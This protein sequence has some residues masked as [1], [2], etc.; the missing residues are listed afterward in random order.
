MASVMVLVM[1]SVMVLV[2]GDGDG[3]DV[4]PPEIITKL[5]QITL[6]RHHLICHSDVTN[7]FYSLPLDQNLQNPKKLNLHLPHAFFFHGSCNGLVLCSTSSA[8]FLN[9]H[10]LVVFNP[11]TKELVQLPECGFDKIINM[12]ECD[13]MY[14]FGYDARTDDYKVVTFCYIHN[15][16]DVYI[17]SLRSKRWTRPVVVNCPCDHSHPHSNG[18]T[19]PVVFVNGIIHW[20]AYKGPYCA[21]VIVGFSLSDETFTEV[22]SPKGV[23]IV[24]TSDCALVVVGEKL[25]VFLNDEV[26]LMSEY[27]VRESWFKISICGFDE[28]PMVDPVILDEDGKIVLVSGGL[29]RIYDVEEKCFCKS[30]DVSGN[31]EGLKVKGAYVESLVS[32]KFI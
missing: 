28:I 8:H 14:A 30:I 9:A 7:S 25:G 24:R 18:K 20:I 15:N 17:Y 26:W 3:D 12:L 23:D 29:V 4:I 2:M 31:V 19:S 32:P 11:T 10:S 21:P 5:H 27:G 16:I 13:V 6:N 1:A 22:P